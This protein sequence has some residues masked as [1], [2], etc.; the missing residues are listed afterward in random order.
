MDDYVAKPISLAALRDAFARCLE[1]N[2]PL[3]KAGH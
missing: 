3:A 2:R 1:A